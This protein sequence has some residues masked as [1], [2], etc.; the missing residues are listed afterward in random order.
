VRVRSAVFTGAAA[1]AGILSAVSLAGTVKDAKALALRVG[2][3]P[4]PVQRVSE[5]ETRA[6]RLPGGT[7][8]LYEATFKLHAGRRVKSVGTIVITAPSVDVARRAFQK[9]AADARATAAAPLALPRLGDQQ[10]A[11]LYGRPALDEASALAWVRMGTVV[12]Q[13]QTSSVSSPFGYSRR[14]ALLELT[15]YARKQQRRV[16]AG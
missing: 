16:S 4:T 6:A 11:A 13:I 1:L 9:V 15:K 8:R 5:T 14:E 12:W 2:D 10:Y 7:G 3:F